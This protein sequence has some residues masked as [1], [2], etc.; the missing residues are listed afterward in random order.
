ML[1]GKLLSLEEVADA[2]GCSVKLARHLVQ[3]GDIPYIRL[4]RQPKG[5]IDSRMYMV[6]EQ[7]LQAFI[8]RNKVVA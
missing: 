6:Q 4:G 2:L 5:R 3:D 1:K 8:D 7:D